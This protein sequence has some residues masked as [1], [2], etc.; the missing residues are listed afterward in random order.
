MPTKGLLDERRIAALQKRIELDIM[1][2][3]GSFCDNN[4]D[5]MS[6]SSSSSSSRKLFAT[7]V[8]RAHRERLAE[9]AC[10]RVNPMREDPAVLL[11]C[12]IQ[13]VCVKLGKE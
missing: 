4:E 8:Q 13:C 9:H 1:Q 7:E 11:K 12:T 10:A 2:D 5:E 6:L 3:I